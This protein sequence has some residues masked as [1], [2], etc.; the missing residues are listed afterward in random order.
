MKDTTVYVYE[1]KMEGKAADDQTWLVV[2]ELS[3]IGRGNFN[4][5]M[6]HVMMEGFKQLTNGKAV[7]GQP[8]VGCVGPYHITKLLIEVRE[9]NA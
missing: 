4:D 7:F 9:E 2:G 8:G 3:V 1:Y 5:T 6:D